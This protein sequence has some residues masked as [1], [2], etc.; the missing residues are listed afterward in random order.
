MTGSELV[1]DV[2]VVGGGPAGE[3]AAGRLADRGLEAVLVERELVGGHAGVLVGV[4][5]TG[6]GVQELVHSATVA[7]A[8]RVP[9]AD[10]RHAVPAFPT[11]SEVWL[12][13]LEALGV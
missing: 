8:G 5:I 6:S 12:H 1:T 11:V 2:V 4:T 7:V 13:A 9:L 10:L 3:V